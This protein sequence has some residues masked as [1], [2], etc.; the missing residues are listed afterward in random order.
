MPHELSKR[1]M[2][3]GLAG[4]IASASGVAWAGV[5]G[6]ARTTRVMKVDVNGCVASV[7]PIFQYLTGGKA[8][9]TRFDANYVEIQAFNTDT[10]VFAT[11]TA[12]PSKIC[13]APAARL[14]LLSFSGLG[15]AEAAR[16]RDTLDQLIGNP[17]TIDCG[18]AVN[19]VR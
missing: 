13:S 4:A 6:W 3:L 17:L 15:S 9:K 16:V 11:C 14:T 7:E 10:A 1:L 2:A 5:P 19:P 8:V 18:T 12:A